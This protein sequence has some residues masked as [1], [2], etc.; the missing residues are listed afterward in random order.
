MKNNQ[1]Y[2]QST[3]PYKKYKLKI[4][5]CKQ[6][7]TNLKEELLPKKNYNKRN[8]TSNNFIFNKNFSLKN[9]FSLLSNTQTDNSISNNNSLIFSKTNSRISLK[10]DNNK[11]NN[12][13]NTPIKLKNNSKKYSLNINN[14]KFVLA[15]ITVKP[16][17]TFKYVNKSKS[18]QYFKKEGKFSKNENNQ[19]YIIN[20]IGIH[21]YKEENNLK[22]KIKELNYK[23]EIR[24][25]KNKIN[26]LLEKYNNIE[27]EKKE[28]DKKIEILE[29]KVDN[30][31]NFIKNNNILILKDKN[32]KLQ[33]SIDDLII[34]NEHL[35]KE[36]NKKKKIFE[37]LSNLKINKSI[38][39]KKEKNNTNSNYNITT[40][41]NKINDLNEI[42]IQN[43]KFISIDPNDF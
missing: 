5:K 23:K 27:T 4:C 3:L 20:N 37:C 25:L 22:D 11:F 2:S 41:N 12:N 35:K 36:I 33:N 6:N 34:E 39:T 15:Q 30:L 19:K 14:H 42:D 26:I 32:K 9:I 43:I 31:M 17:E 1:R 18:I 38:G 24:K 29:E 16:Q 8:R 28:K 13:I 40:S 21:A 10:N 7:I